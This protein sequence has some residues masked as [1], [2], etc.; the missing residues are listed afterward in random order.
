M[1]TAKASASGP[2]AI[3]LDTNLVLS[4][5]VFASGRLS[6]LRAAW[7]AERCVPLVS[8]ATA[9]ELLRVLAYPKF[10]LSAGDQEEL[11]ADYLPYCRSVRMPA[12]LPK[13]P[14][15]RD[16]ADQMFIE[17]AAVGRA[18]FLVTGDKGLLALT[19]SVGFAIVPAEAFLGR[20]DT[21]A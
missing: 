12:R 10:K 15:C 20:L 14:V 16:P 7:R 19:S 13:L 11:L 17:L 8:Q 18:R 2:P 21:P 3:V 4:A 1:P 5:L 6:A 9:S